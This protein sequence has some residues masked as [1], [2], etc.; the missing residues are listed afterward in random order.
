MGLKV[1]ACN[2]TGS[3]SN[4][5]RDELA[6]AAAHMVTDF[7]DFGFASTYLVSKEE[8]MQLFH[9]MLNE[10]VTASPDVV[11]MEFADGLLQRETAMLLREAEIKKA[12]RGVVLAAG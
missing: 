9:T 4:H 8:L 11:L 1:V 10:V 12:G 6:G 2:L 3:V 5:D 7:S